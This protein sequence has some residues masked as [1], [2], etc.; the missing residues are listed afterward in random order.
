MYNQE[1]FFP[2][3][4]VIFVLNDLIY[5]F[6]GR[7]LW[8]FAVDSPVLNNV[9]LIFC[10][11]SLLGN[12]EGPLRPLC[13]SSHE[14]DDSFPSFALSNCLSMQEIFLISPGA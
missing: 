12:P 3:S 1:V 5:H 11:L 10:D 8:R 14:T 9:V 7:P 4:F 2:P 13:V 6:M